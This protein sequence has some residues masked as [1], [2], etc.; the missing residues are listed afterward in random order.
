MCPLIPFPKLF[1]MTALVPQKPSAPRANS[2]APRKHVVMLPTP[3][4][5]T[6]SSSSPTILTFTVP[7]PG[8][9]AESSQVAIALPDLRRRVSF[10]EG[11]EIIRFLQDETSF[12]RFDRPPASSEKDVREELQ[13]P[14]SLKSALPHASHI[15]EVQPELSAP[16]A[17]SSGP[18][19]PQHLLDRSGGGLADLVGDAWRP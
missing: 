4:R 10:T 6:R 13:E 9:G 3:P 15:V 8:H 18:L 19:P 11:P 14:V 7:S 1:P 12:D 17:L 5:T 16:E 2:C